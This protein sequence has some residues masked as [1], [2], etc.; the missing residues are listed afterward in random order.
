MLELVWTSLG[1]VRNG[2]VMSISAANQECGDEEKDERTAT[3]REPLVK[4]A[5]QC[6]SLQSP[7][8]MMRLSLFQKHGISIGSEEGVD[9]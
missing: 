8:C 4:T 5:R 3:A 1:T 6:C 2:L 7:E 9:I